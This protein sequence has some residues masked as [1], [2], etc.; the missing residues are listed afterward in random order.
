MDKIFYDTAMF[1]GGHAL[2]LGH[3]PEKLTMENINSKLESEPQET[4]QFGLFDRSTP[5]YTTYYPEVTA[6]DLNPS[7]DEFIEPVFR[8]L[9]NITVNA[10]HNPIYFPADVLKQNMYKMIGQTV[11]IDHETAVGNAIGSVKAVEWQNAYTANG[12]K[13]PAGFNAT[14]KID[15]KSNPRIARGILMDPPSIHSNSVTV[16]FAWKPSHPKMPEDEFRNKLGTFGE[17]G[18]LVQRVVTDIQNYHETSLVSHGADP[19]AQLI[20]DGKIVNPSYAGTRYPL[21]DQDI[22]KSKSSNYYSWDWKSFNSNEITIPETINN[23]NDNQNSENMKELLT[24]LEKFLGMEADSLTEEN[25]EAT[26]GEIDFAALKA[27]AEKDPEPVK[28]LDLEGIEAIETEIT[29][30]RDKMA[31]VPEN[32]SEQLALAKTGEIAVTSLRAETKRLYG[33]NVEAGKED[34]TILAMI[35]S[36]DYKTLVSLHKQY[37]ELTEGKFGFVCN[38]CNSHNVTRASA[39]PGADDGNGNPVNKSNQDVINKFTSVSS[40]KRPSW[41]AKEQ[42]K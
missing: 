42:V 6:E 5:N 27:K 3:K 13:V 41:M 25:Y 24:F 8:M 33:L 39:N 19:F 26:I 32:L 17:D 38:D 23:N 18:K 2:I 34:A 9:S 4:S 31:G 30:L 20:K 12:V 40:V 37:D 14:I 22:E 11:N 16:T 36:A 10:R 21:S 7:E 35:E 29:Q 28:V 15:G 1:F